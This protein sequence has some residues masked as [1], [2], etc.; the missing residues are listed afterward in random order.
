MAR[1]FIT[2]SSAGLGLMAARLLIEQGHQVV[3]HGRDRARTESALADAAGTEAGVT[4]DLSRLSDMRSVAEQANRLGRFDAVIHNAGIGYREPRRIETPDG[5]PHVLAVN[6]V[7]P[8]VL[9]ALMERPQRLVYLSSGMHQH[10]GA[11]LDDLLWTK[12]AWQGAE[13]YA[14]SKFYDAILAFAVARLWPEVRSNALEPGWVPTRMGGP[15]APGDLSKAHLTQA[16]LAVSRDPDALTSGGY[17][18]HQRLRAA[19]P[20]AQDETVQTRLLAACARL[21]GVKLPGGPA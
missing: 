17:F 21:S 14:E 1:V 9:T 7:A 20:A 3:V 2:G 6:V 15:G 12:R 16:W 13:A 10:A 19:N 4:G 18:Y 5:L 8:Y 11:N